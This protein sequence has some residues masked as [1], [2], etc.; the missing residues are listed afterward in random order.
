MAEKV[1]GSGLRLYLMDG[2]P[3]PTPKLV[4]EQLSLSNNRSTNTID[5]TSKDNEGYDE[6]I[7]GIKSGEITFEMIMDLTVDGTTAVNYATM[8]TVEDARQVRSYQLKLETPTKILTYAFKALITQFNDSAP[9]EDKITISVTLK[10]SGK[11][12]STIVA[13]NP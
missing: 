2:S 4:T 13:A 11:P 3:T 6:F 8:L 1:N 10:R 7:G 12:T 9:M 5:V